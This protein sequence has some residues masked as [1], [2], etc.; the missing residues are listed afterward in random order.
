MRKT[1]LL[2]TVATSIAPS[3]GMDSRG[4][5]LK[6]SSVLMTAR[7]SQSDWRTAQSG[8]GKLTRRRVF[9]LASGTVNQSLGNGPV[10][11]VARSNRAWTSA[12]A[13]RLLPG[14]KIRHQ[15]KSQNVFLVMVPKHAS[16]Q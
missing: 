5:R 14:E 6:P 7:S 3:K 8:K 12:S 1:V 10:V 13:L 4:W 11:G 15:P 9:C 16:N 2:L